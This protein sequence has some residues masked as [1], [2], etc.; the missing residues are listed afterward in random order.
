MCLIIPRFHLLIWQFHCFSDLR[1]LL[2][3]LFLH[4]YWTIRY[5]CFHYFLIFKIILRFFLIRYLFVLLDPGLIYF[6]HLV[7]Y[8]FNYY[9]PL[10]F[11]ILN[12]LV[13]FLEL[14]IYLTGI[15]F[16]CY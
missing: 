3:I 14:L 5:F 11:V 6:F 13:S 1:Y 10:F 16:L 15:I 12:V 7:C 9:F 8:H 2:I 4:C